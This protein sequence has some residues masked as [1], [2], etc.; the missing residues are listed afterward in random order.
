MI[1]FCTWI[2]NRF[3]QFSQVWELNLSHMN[4]NDE[5][6]IVDAGSNDGFESWVP[7]DSRI[8]IIRHPMHPLNFSALYNISHRAGSHPI[9]VNL[10]ADNYLGPKFCDWAEE[11][12][13]QERMGHAWSN[14]WEDGTYGRIMIPSTTF[15]RIG[16]YDE[17]LSPCGFQDT[18]LIKRAV[19]TGIRCVTCNDPDVYGGAIPNTRED[20]MTYTDSPLSFGQCNSINYH[21]A[22][23]KW[24]PESS[25]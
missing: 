20:T 16:G 17:D 5:W 11:I 18:D 12:H 1:S 15:Q 13:Y 21:K 6:V 25:A 2:K 8:R 3:H 19:A 4:P 23:E 22:L 10:D 24:N 7:S 9:L 14:V